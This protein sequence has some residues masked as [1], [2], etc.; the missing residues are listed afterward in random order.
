VAS[1]QLYVAGVPLRR[2][3]CLH[4]NPRAAGAGACAAR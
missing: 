2:K 1:E 4:A 3:P